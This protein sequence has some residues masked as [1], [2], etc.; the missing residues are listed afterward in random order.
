M[1]QLLGF[2]PERSVVLIGYSARGGSA[3]GPVLRCDLPPR[4]ARREVAELMVTRLR[5]TG[6]P[7]AMIVVIGESGASEGAG[8][9]TIPHTSLARMIG[10]ELKRHRIELRESLWTRAIRTGAP[11]RCYLHRGCRGRLPDPSSTVVAAT[12]AGLGLVTAGSRDE[13]ARQFEPDDADV[14]RVRSELIDAN[15]REVEGKDEPFSTERGVLAMRAALE[16]SLRGRLS[17]S[18]AE[19]ADLALALCDVRIRDA[20][21]ATA[22]PPT[23]ARALAASNL[24]LA[25]T[26]ALPAPERAE[27][28]CLAGYAAY[29][30]G[31]GP[32][33]GIALE[34]ALEANPAHLLSALLRRALEHGMDPR[35]LRDLGRAEEIRLWATDAAEAD[36]C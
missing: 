35:L 9:L 8:E 19:L 10:R 20:C 3:I 25:L 24:W 17:M 28:A 15:L 21:L 11:W 7:A 36:G 13:L 31:E 2:R 34:T 29:Q 32:L 27:A 18:D 33:A 4:Q 14:L 16:G 22:R 23:S 1:P 12:A 26:R 30:R 6:S 5:Q